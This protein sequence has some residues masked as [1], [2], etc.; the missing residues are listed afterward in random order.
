MAF[1]YGEGKLLPVQVIETLT[2]S[3]IG[4]VGEDGVPFSRE[5]EETYETADEARSA[6]ENHTWTPIL[7]T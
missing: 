5:S 1:C 4:T 2:G 3:Y 6:L 7:F